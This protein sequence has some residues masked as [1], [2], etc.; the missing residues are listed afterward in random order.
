M[1]AV[2][3][4][5][6]SVAH[7]SDY[8]FDLQR[9]V[10]PVGNTG[11]YIQYAAARLRSI[12]R[13]AGLSPDAAAQRKNHVGTPEER[14]LA[15]LVLELGPTTVAVGRHLEP[16]RLCDYLFSLAQA[17]SVFY[18]QCPVVNADDDALRASRLALC[19]ATLRALATGLDLLGIEAPERM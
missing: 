4:A 17:F 13:T 9:M 16:H 6:L 18:E 11:P 7:D 12:F 14:A 10:A 8:V 15:L 2:K 5:D 19:A 1:A 3:Y